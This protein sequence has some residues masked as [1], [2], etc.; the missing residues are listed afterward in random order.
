MFF[1]WRSE[2]KKRPLDVAHNQTARRNRGRATAPPE[3]VLDKMRRNLDVPDA[4][5]AH[6]VVYAVAENP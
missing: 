6:E 5:E 1:L 3:A 4:T 2:T